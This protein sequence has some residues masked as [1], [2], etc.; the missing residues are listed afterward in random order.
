[1]LFRSERQKLQ[2]EREA[3]RTDRERE[4]LREFVDKLQLD[5]D[6]WRQGALEREMEL[7]ILRRKAEHNRRAWVMTMGALD[8]AEDELYRIKHGTERPEFTPNRAAHVA[9][10]EEI[11]GDAGDATEEESPDAAAVS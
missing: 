1:M 5:R 3:A 4:R 2:T 6:R 7:R 8:L 11:G 10:A 9:A